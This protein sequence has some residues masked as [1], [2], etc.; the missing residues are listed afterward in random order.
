MQEPNT[1]EFRGGEGPSM[2][3]PRP[4]DEH[5]VYGISVA[6]DLVGMGAQRLRLYEARGL[7]QPERTAGGT[8]RYSANDLDRLRRIGD[9]LE[10]GLNLAGIG[11]VLD[12]EAQNAR[13][14]SGQEGAAMVPRNAIDP[15][16]AAPAAGIGEQQATLVTGSPVEPHDGTDRPEQQAAV[17][18]PQDDDNPYQPVATSWSV[19]DPLVEVAARV[20]TEFA[21]QLT[22]AEVLAVVERCSADL[23][24]PSAEA[25]PE[26]VERLARQR[27]A[28]GVR[29]DQPRADPPAD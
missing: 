7:L 18:G 4:D 3:P 15:N 29:R 13:T 2:G 19:A 16:P 12:L 11:M 8:R 23:D 25:L 17:N 20:Y 1:Q 5:G 6:A 21:E 10:A 14:E 28:S 27:L 9:L 26:L 22:L 24:P